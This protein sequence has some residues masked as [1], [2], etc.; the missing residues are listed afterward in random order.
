[1]P[2]TAENQ[3]YK[4]AIP[5]EISIPCVVCPACG[6]TDMRLNRVHH[7]SDGQISLQYRCRSAKCLKN[8]SVV[9][10]EKT[11]PLLY[12]SRM[13]RKLTDE[14]VYEVLTSTQ[15]VTALGRRLNVSRQT[16]ADI[17]ANRRYQDVH[18]SILREEHQPQRLVAGSCKKCVHW[19]NDNC[20]LAFPEGKTGGYAPLCSSFFEDAEQGVANSEQMVY[21]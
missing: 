3:K 7:R 10:G 19:F 16:I 6:R 13:K 2:T 11:G 14:Q 5:S 20:S 8:L 21:H 9:V 15:G 1:M 17:R 18:P 12:A 4:D